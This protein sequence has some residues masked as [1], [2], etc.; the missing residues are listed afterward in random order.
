MP[1]RRKPTAFEVSFPEELEAAESTQDESASGQNSRRRPHDGAD[2]DQ[3]V[4]MSC[5]CKSI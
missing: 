2:H 3:E 4:C 1:P 5:D